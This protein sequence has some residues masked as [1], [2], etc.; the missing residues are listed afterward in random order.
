F[1]VPCRMHTMGLFTRSRPDSTR[2]PPPSPSPLPA[3]GGKGKV[4]GGKWKRRLLVAFL[5]FLLLVLLSP[6]LIARTPLRNWLVAAALK[7]FAGDVRIGGASLGWFRPLVFTDIEV[8]DRDGRTLLRAPRVEGSKSLAA[9]LCR[10]FDLGE[11]HFTQ[12]ALH[13]VCCRD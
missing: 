11:F 5:L 1:T 4:R 10:P 8:R 13:I 6:I 2:T 9:L 3:Q 12:T 7:Q